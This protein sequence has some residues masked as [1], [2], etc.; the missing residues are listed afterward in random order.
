M[1]NL[2]AAYE[3]IAEQEKKDEEEEIDS[4]DIDY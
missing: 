1:N 4:N 3:C 2:N